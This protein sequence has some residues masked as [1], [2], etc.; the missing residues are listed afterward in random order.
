MNHIAEH[1]KAVF[2]DHDD[3]LVNTIEP[4]WKLH[5]HVA[6]EHYGKNLTDKELS[7]HWGKPLEQLVSILYGTDDLE[8]AITHIS[9]YHE[10]YK[11]RFF[12]TTI[13]IL[14]RL[15]EA[16]KL[17]G[18]ITATSREYLEMDLTNHA[19]A[20]KFIDYTQ[21]SDDT[22]FHKPDPRVFEPALSWL[23][24]HSIQPEEVL[25]VGDSLNDA[26][27]ALG[28][29]LNFLGVETGLFTAAQFR[30]LGHRSIPALTNFFD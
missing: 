24:E 26:A 20:R 5:K 7:E 4:I 10:I 22:Q 2:F 8:T 23:K 19:A 16:H 6:R 27:A 17:V 15:H 25:Y 12:D 29:G 9:R 11:K 21:A 1:I 13:P 3:T 28:A 30:K 18:I 14:K